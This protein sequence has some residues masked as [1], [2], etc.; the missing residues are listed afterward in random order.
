[1]NA[2][3]IEIRTDNAGVTVKITLAVRPILDQGKSDDAISSVPESELTAA[4][5]ILNS[6]ESM[7]RTVGISAAH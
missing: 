7:G 6:I 3:E 2:G 4:R 1:M 5:R